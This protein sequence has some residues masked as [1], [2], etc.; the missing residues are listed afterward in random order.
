MIEV[1]FTFIKKRAGPFLQLAVSLATGWV[2]MLI[3]KLGHTAK[4]TEYFAAMVAIIFYTLINTV[5]SIAH[6]SFLRYTIPSYYIYIILVVL[7]LLSAKLISGI[8]IWNLEEYR[9]MVVS[10][11]MF[12]L[13]VSLL[14]RGV[15]FIYEIAEE[16][17]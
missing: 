15:R 9:M 17:N 10:V 8:S 11:T 16:D 7:L 5:V 4:G 2:G 1:T 6:K 3:C 12:Y 13:I 14:V